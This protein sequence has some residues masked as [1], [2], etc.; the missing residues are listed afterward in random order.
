MTDETMG[1]TAQR[2]VLEAVQE[3]LER[4]RLDVD[5]LDESQLSD[6]VIQIVDTYIDM[7]HRQR[8]MPHQVPQLTKR[9]DTISNVVDHFRS[10]GVLGPFMRDDSI[11]EVQVSA[12]DKIMLYHTSGEVHEAPSVFRDDKAVE[13]Q[14]R[15]MLA[16]DPTGTKHLDERHPIV[17]AM[18]ANGSRLHIVGPPLARR[19]KV[20]IRKVVGLPSPSIAALTSNGTLCEAAGDFLGLAWDAGLSVLV[21]GPM[22]AGKTTILRAL[23]ADTD[24]SEHVVVV[25]EH[26]EIDP[27]ELLHPN[28]DSLMCR[29]SDDAQLLVTLQDLVKETMRM[30]ATRVIVGEVRGPEAIDLLTAMST[31]VPSASTLY[32]QTASEAVS[33]FS[34]Y[35]V[36]SG[37]IQP[38][39]A[40]E[41]IALAL[42]L[43]VICERIDVWIDD[44]SHN[45]PRVTEI[46]AVDG[47][48]S[49]HGNVLLKTL[50]SYDDREQ[51]LDCHGGGK[52]ND[53]QMKAF[54]RSGI[55]INGFFRDLLGEVASP[56]GVAA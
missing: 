29:H 19:Y 30:L 51:R 35:M 48:L 18:L 39:E 10:F 32:A 13:R 21:G 52:F 43:I 26:P 1:K 25:E 3:H 22:G 11:Y 6:L 7:F 28:L 49:V 5:D 37:L 34:H 45:V 9:E 55:D 23:L 27:D 15:R 2:I 16:S 12:P 44:E 47:G 24:P 38:R 50:F 36:R 8:G 20:N 33:K 31:G 4:E 56:G 40:S 46:A 17:N 41:G 42:D 53:R 14:L 54:D